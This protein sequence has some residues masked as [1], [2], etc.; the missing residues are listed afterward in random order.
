LGNLF[1]QYVELRHCVWKQA[2]GIHSFI[3]SMSASG[4]LHYEK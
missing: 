4:T 2:K 3:Y 1:P